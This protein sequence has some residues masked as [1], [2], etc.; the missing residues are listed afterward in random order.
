[1]AGTPTWT[2]PRDWAA[3]EEI[4]ETI[5]NQHVRDNLLYL[6]ANGQSGAILPFF[7]M[8]A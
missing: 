1:M 5:M 4:D 6:Y 3:L 7:L 2:T 8:G